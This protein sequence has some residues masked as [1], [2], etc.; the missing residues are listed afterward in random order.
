MKPI[1]TVLTLLLVSPFLLAPQ[2]ASAQ[3]AAGVSGAPTAL[4]VPDAAPPARRIRSAYLSAG[5]G[6]ALPLVHVDV[7][8][9][10]APRVVI[11][12]T[13]GL[14]IF[15]PLAGVGA[16]V[17]LLGDGE[18]PTHA[19]VL[20][21]HVLVDPTLGP[22]EWRSPGAESLGAGV[23]LLAGYRFLSD[24][25]FLFRATAGGLVYTTGKQKIEAGPIL[26][27]LTFGAAF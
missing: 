21:G 25:G 11:E 26:L 14:Y 24:G 23:D 15:S 27:S 20:G 3:Q 9:F 16:E 8:V 10:V 6:A 13:A 1:A 19:L 2:Q 4:S 5:F 18:Q 7:G 12:A 22:S 17:H